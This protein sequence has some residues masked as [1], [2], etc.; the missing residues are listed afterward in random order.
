MTDES[1]LIPAHK[2]LKPAM[3]RMS[4]GERTAFVAGEAERR[5]AMWINARLVE[6]SAKAQDKRFRCRALSGDSDY[7][8]TI[9]A[10]LSVSCN[11]EDSRGEGRIGSLKNATLREVFAAPP[12][13]ELRKK[14][15]R[16]EIPI[17]RCT[18]CS[19]FERIPA[20]EAERWVH[21]YRLPT[22]G[23]MLETNA[24]CNLSC[25]A[26]YRVRRPLERTKM[27]LTDVRRVA[28]QLYELRIE[29][30]ALFALGEPF[31]SNNILDEMRALREEH[32]TLK[33]GTCTNGVLVDTQAK[34]DAALEM[35]EIGFSI[36]GCDQQTASRYQVGTDF[37]KAYAN[38]SALVRHRARAGYGPHIEWK[39][40][41]FRWN[42]RAEHVARTVE[43]ARAA[44]VD[45]LSF[46]HT[47]SPVYG[48]SARFFSSRH[49]RDLAPVENRRRVLHFSDWTRTALRTRHS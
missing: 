47:F 12:A 6:L 39:Y 31:T 15:A 43:L 7:N 9:N 32:P 23:I 49:F 14:L 28:R 21:D 3:Q 1:R 17:S 16:G 27:R 19:D 48:I 34:L 18:R 8:I 36:D 26:C 20:T 30:I 46:W 11:C 45:T 42:D 41:V 35:D 44:G 25:L 2:L 10:D 24:N 22:K 29:H 33:I 40:V 38:I 37:A 4:A 13:M 5:G